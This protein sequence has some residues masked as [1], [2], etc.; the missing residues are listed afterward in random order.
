LDASGSSFTNKHASSLCLSITLPA[1]SVAGNI[2]A[3]THKPSHAAV[4]RVDNRR[5]T[6]SYQPQDS[7]VM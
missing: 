3:A 7:T 5:G 1:S 6:P 4:K 2:F